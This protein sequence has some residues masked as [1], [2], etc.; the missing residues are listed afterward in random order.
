[1]PY[2]TIPVPYRGYQI[3]LDDILNGVDEKTFYARSKNTHDTRTVYRATTPHRLLENISIQSL[4][5]LLAEFNNKY[6]HLIDTKN[7]SS[8]YHSFYIP[9]RH[10][11]LRQINAPK[12]E[13]ML[14]LRELKLLFETRLFASY[15]TSAF[16]YIFGRCTVDAVKRHQQNNSRWFLK[17]DF[18]DFFGS[19]TPEF[20]MLQLSTI[21]PYNEIVKSVQGKKELTDAL[22]LCFLN[23]GLPQGTPI[24]PL[25]TNLMMIPFDHAVAKEM[26]EHSPHI[27]YTRYADDILLSSDLAFENSEAIFAIKKKAEYIKSLDDEHIPYAQKQARIAKTNLQIKELVNKTKVLKLLFEISKRFGLTF[28]INNAK[29]RYGSISGRNWNLGIMLNKD[30]QLSIGNRKK[31]HLKVML[32]ALVNDY[33]RGTVWNLNDVQILSGQISY[34]KMVEPETID[35][36]ID[37][38]S[39]KTGVDIPNLI[40]QIL[41]HKISS[42]P[43]HAAMS[44]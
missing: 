3:T 31:K 24:S 16:A 38:Y 5:D 28:Q 40:K 41:S 20:L 12:E 43:A 11:G 39:K 30:N 1:M 29:T 44:V 4:I 7:K 14:A 25:L 13:L 9:K 19:T 34:Y 42:V 2:I 10:G 35:K 27:C 8:L 23:G 32:F 21:F 22:S 17:L 15:H 37:D 6:R 18:H 36:L 33:K 26:R